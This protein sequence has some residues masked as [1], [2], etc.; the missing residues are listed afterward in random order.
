MD[1]DGLRSF[2]LSLAGVT[3]DVKWGADL[4]F[5]VANKMFCVTGLESEFS[6]SIKVRNEEFDDMCARQ[7]ITPAPY[8]ARSK[9]VHVTGGNTL[10]EAEWEH[11]IWQSY[12]LIKAKLPAGIKKQIG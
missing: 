10:S 9:W 2:C 8:L 4:C 1:I 12:D 7:G 5:L 6:V 3:E 11:Y